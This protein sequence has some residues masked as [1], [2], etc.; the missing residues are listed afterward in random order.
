MGSAGR[1]AA[2]E[3][4]YLDVFISAQCSSKL[5]RKEEDNGAG[6]MMALEFPWRLSSNGPD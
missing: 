6:R 4:V 5:K 3:C 1:R 2:P